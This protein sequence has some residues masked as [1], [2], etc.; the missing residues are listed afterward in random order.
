V[1][2]GICIFWTFGLFRIHRGIGS[3]QWEFLIL[4][5]QATTH[6]FLNCSWLCAGCIQELCTTSDVPRVHCGHAPWGL[7]ASTPCWESLLPAQTSGLR[8]LLC[9]CWQGWARHSCRASLQTR[10]PALSSYAILCSGVASACLCWFRGSGG[11]PR[12]SQA[13]ICATLETPS[14]SSGGTPTTSTHVWLWLHTPERE[15]RWGV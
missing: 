3:L 6:R 14:S 1:Y 15:T 4:G 7:R 9:V 11:M 12:R 10:F 13:W 5:T 2:R 8:W